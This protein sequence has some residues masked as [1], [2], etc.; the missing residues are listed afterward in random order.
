M[1]TI[2]FHNL[3]GDDMTVM[4]NS[5]NKPH[6]SQSKSASRL[7]A[8]KSAEA[9]ERVLPQKQQRRKSSASSSVQA[10][11]QGFRKEHIL[12]AQC[13]YICHLCH[14]VSC[15]SREIRFGR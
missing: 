5:K 11:G 8:G 9:S 14:H 3:S 15:K 6:P 13:A 4:S 1:R 2:F 7:G 12:R 10:R